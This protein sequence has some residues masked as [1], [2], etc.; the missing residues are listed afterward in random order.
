MP[1]IFREAKAL[2]D[3]KSQFDMTEEEKQTVGAATIP[4]M[5]LPRYRDIPIG[6]G[7][8]ELANILEEA[9]GVI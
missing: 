4:L 8:E 2:L 7:L 6:E 9:K 5:I 3:T 1:N